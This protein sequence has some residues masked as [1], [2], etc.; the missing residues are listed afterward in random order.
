MD[1]LENKN[2]LVTGSSSGIG[3]SIAENFAKN[4]SNIGIHY[5]V[6]KKGAEDLA[7][8]LSKL[9]KVRV[10]EQDLSSDKLD[11]IDKF[12]KDFGSIDILINNAGTISPKSFLDMSIKDYNEIFNVNS[13]AAFIL[14]KDAF[15]YMKKNR[16]GRIINISSFVVKYGKGR[17]D[18]IQYAASKATLDV[19]TNGLSVMGGKY[20]ILV[21]S[22]RPGVILTRLQNNTDLKIKRE[23][24]PLQK[25]GTTEDIANMAVY[26]A[27]DK[28]RF[29][30]GE[31]ITISGGE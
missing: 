24:N 7:N 17:N 20:N 4:G 16:F 22:I 25:L 6:N 11:L 31:V 2:V 23:R 27:S 30:T 29:I 12:V 5:R 14:A 19:L 3:A 13:R 8:K 21:N 28:G 9:T 10:Y 18:S 1:S 15:N 26:L